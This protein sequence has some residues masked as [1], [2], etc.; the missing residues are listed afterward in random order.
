MSALWTY[1][2]NDSVIKYEVYDADSIIDGF[3]YEYYEM[4]KRKLTQFS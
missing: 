3:I 2:R 4:I 1:V